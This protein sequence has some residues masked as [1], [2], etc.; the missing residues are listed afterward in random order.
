MLKILLT[1]KA[2]W[3][4]IWVNQHLESL[5]YRKK[6]GKHQCIHCFSL[7]AGD[8][9]RECWSSAP[10]GIHA[11][12]K[13]AGICT[14]HIVC[15]EKTKVWKYYEDDFITHQINP[16]WAQLAMLVVPAGPKPDLV[17]K[18]ETR[19][20][21]KVGLCVSASVC[22]AMFSQWNLY[23]RRYEI[24]H[25]Q[26][27]VGGTV[28]IS[29]NIGRGGRNSGKGRNR[30]LLLFPQRVKKTTASSPKRIRWIKG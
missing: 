5:D 30:I 28:G 14:T 25:F 23:Q 21:G 11:L 27:V 22:N 1:P 19:R 16:A 26:Q 3:C 4:L 12:E 8:V 7:F 13:P 2:F 6:W 10:P 29:G 15:S 17:Q 24:I 20:S 9:T 18:V